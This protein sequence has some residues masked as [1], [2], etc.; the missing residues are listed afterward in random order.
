MANRQTLIIDHQYADEAEWDRT[1]K[2]EQGRTRPFQGDVHR[3]FGLVPILE[4]PPARPAAAAPSSRAAP[5]K[6]QSRAP[7]G[8][9]PHV[10][11]TQ[12]VHAIASA[13]GHDLQQLSLAS[14]YSAEEMKLKE[15]EHH[16]RGRLIQLAWLLAHPKSDNGQR[17]SA[18]RRGAQRLRK[19][20]LNVS[21]EQRAR[22]RG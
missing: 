3:R 5:H 7:G 18:L 17:G 19:N 16:A 15:A 13:Q 11:I 14:G 6:A 10:L 12:S 21:R 2:D 8:P 9:S 1:I 20:E 4:V 22:R